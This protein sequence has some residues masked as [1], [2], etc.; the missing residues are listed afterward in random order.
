MLKQAKFNIEQIK[1]ELFIAQS[2]ER[3][4]APDQL[5]GNLT[6]LLDEISKAKLQKV[7]L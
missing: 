4:L 3:H 5:Q 6:A 2:D 7:F 1:L